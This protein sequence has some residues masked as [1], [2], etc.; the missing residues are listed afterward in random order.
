MRKKILSFL[1]IFQVLLPVFGQVADKS[2]YLNNI[3]TELH[4]KWPNNR[5]IN[6]VFHGHSVPTGYYTAA[7]G[8]KTFDSYPFYTLKLLKDKYNFAVVN[9]IITSI[10][11]ENAIQGAKRFTK[12]VLCHQPDVLFIDYSLNDRKQDFEK[13]RKSWESMIKKALKK[14]IKVIVFTPTPDLKENI[15]DEN[16]PLELHANQVRELA[17]KYKIGLVDSYAI[18][19]KLAKEGVALKDYMSQNNHPN[20]KGHQLVAQE[21]Y[22]WFLQADDSTQK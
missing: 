20:E 5:T 10:G 9:C 12:E 16:T 21:I 2:T 1:L 19:K 4:K 13:V 18:F 6:L 3:V 7:I 8:V 15:L 22:S 11:G 14:N 17:A